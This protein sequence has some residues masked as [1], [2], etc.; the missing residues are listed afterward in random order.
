MGVVKAEVR[1]PLDHCPKAA[2]TRLI[3]TGWEAIS[4]DETY[5]PHSF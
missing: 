4:Y 3:K 5:C 1:H 2:F